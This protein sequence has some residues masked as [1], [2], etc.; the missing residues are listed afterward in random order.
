[1]PKNVTCIKTDA[2]EDD[3]SLVFSFG[4]DSSVF[5]TWDKNSKVEGLL[6]AFYHSG[7]E[8]ERENLFGQL[9]T[10]FI[11]ATPYIIDKNPGISVYFWRFRVFFA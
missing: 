3:I 4:E 10:A 9:H 11:P 5:S 7:S 8:E 1:M 6:L 2:F